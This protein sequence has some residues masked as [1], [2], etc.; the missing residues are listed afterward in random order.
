MKRVTNQ[1]GIGCHT[2][3]LEIIPA[4]YKKLTLNYSIPV[5]WYNRLSLDIMYVMDN[6]T[7]LLP[8]FMFF[9]NDL[10]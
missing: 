1:D 10:Q 9:L 3:R 4:Q 8:Y 7:S 6:C 2:N 5:K